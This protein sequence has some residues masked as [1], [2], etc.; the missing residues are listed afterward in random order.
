M[1]AQTQRKMK[2]IQYILATIL[3]A[4]TITSCS[5]EVRPVRSHPT[6][7]TPGGLIYALPNTDICV[8]ITLGHYNTDGATMA[9]YSQEMLS[10]ENKPHYDLLGIKVSTRVSADP[11]NYY[12]VQPKGIALQVDERNLLRSIGIT[13]S[14]GDEWEE[15]GLSELADLRLT[16]LEPQY[17]YNLYDRSDTFYTRFDH[18]GHPS[19]IASKKDSRSQRQQAQDM[20]ERIGQLQERRQQLLSGELETSYTPEGIKL[21][22]QLIDRQ[23]KQLQEQFIGQYTTETIRITYTPKDERVLIDS[24][25]VVLFYYSPT[26]GIVAENTGDAMEV[27]CHIRCDNTLRNATKF[28]KYRLGLFNKDNM[29]GRNTFKYRRSE[30]ADV[31]ITCPLFTIEKQL[32]IA[33]FGPTIELPKGSF[34][35]LFDPRTGDLIYFAD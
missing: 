12:F 30:M 16:N 11:K 8:D 29:N 31:T 21:L 28:V 5:Y 23:E 1:Q 33:Q 15:T 10:S 26:R 7:A 34:K 35:A 25:S 22:L 20:A 19:M 9:K 17:D 32:P 27:W 14:D 4:L 18:P 3:V 2:T 6:M 24:Q 13:A